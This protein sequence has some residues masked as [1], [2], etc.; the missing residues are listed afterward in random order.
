MSNQ[1]CRSFGSCAS[2]R[3]MLGTAPR[4]RRKSAKRSLSEGS[5]CAGSTA[6]TRDMLPPVGD[7]DVQ[8][9]VGIRAVAV[10]DEHHLRAV[11]REAGEAVEAVVEGQAAQPVS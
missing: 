3:N 8:V 6:A 2:V 7:E 4:S 10:R 11:R 1:V 9:L 5:A